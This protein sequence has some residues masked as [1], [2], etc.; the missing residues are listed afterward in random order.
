MHS[1]K[2]KC[3]RAIHTMEY[4]SAIK[5]NKVLIPATT[6]MN[7]ENIMLK[8]EARDFPGGLVTKTSRS[9][10]RAPEFE[11]WSRK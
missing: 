7:L 8:R 1:G 5:R 10:G 4:H 3:G 2:S 6:E 9:Q 11:P